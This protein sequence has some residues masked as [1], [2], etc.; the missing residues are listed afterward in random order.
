M[1]GITFPESL[2]QE[3]RDENVKRPPYHRY[4]QLTA[5]FAQA[6]FV[7]G[8][9]TVPTDTDCLC[10]FVSGRFTPGAAQTAQALTANIL[11]M[12]SPGNTYDLAIPMVT[13]AV[14]ATLT[15]FL[16]PYNL[17]LEAGTF[18]QF[19]ALFSAGAANNTAQVSVMLCQYPKM[20]L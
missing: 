6:S 8:N 5:T 14:A 16:F 1:S 19:S 3:Y 4:L 2:Y 11:P 12:T 13:P 15:G 17:Y 18:V 7:V 20:K 10:G 9:F